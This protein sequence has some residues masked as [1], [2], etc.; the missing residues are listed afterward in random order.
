[1]LR[2]LSDKEELFFKSLV[3]ML[4]EALEML[5]NKIVVEVS[6]NMV[7]LNESQSV[8]LLGEHKKNIYTLIKERAIL[9]EAEYEEFKNDPEVQRHVDEMMSDLKTQML[10]EHSGGEDEGNGNLQ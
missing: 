6:N 3:E 2:N 10:L 5:G 4:E 7:E 1:M 8:K 9:L